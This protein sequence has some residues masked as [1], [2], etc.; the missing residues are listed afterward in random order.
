MVTQQM[1]GN[2][3]LMSLSFVFLQKKNTFLKLLHPNLP[4]SIRLIA[5]CSKPK[6]I[7]MEKIQFMVAFR[8]PTVITEKFSRL[9]PKQRALVNDYFSEGKL[10]S[11]CVSLETAQMWAIFN[12]HNQTD[13]IE[14]LTRLPLT[15]FTTYEISELT[16]ANLVSV[17]MPQFSLN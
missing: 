9:I 16:F 2:F 17:G 15:R 11:Y 7:T 8:L 1:Q 13:V 10:T 12:A 6:P 14:L 4:Y 3:A 5:I